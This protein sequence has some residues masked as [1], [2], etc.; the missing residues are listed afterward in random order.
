M[1]CT[2]IVYIYSHFSLMNYIPTYIHIFI[3][4]YEVKFEVHTTNSLNNRFLPLLPIATQGVLSVDDDIVIPCD[5]LER[6]VRVW[7]SNKK[8]PIPA[9][10]HL[11][12]KNTQD[13]NK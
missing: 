11:V 7:T 13:T 9:L 10:N 12:V 6:S 1:S 3:L 8:V 2:Y 5:V 4:L